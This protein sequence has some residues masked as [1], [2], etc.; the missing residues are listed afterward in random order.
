MPVMDGYESTRLIR[1]FE[2]EKALEPSF[3][4]AVSGNFISKSNSESDELKVS[5]VTLNSDHDSNSLMRVSGTNAYIS[6]PFNENDIRKGLDIFFETEIEKSE[7]TRTPKSIIK[8]EILMENSQEKT[9]D[10]EKKKK[11]EILFD[12]FRKYLHSILFLLVFFGYIKY[13]NR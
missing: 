3:I 12:F 11:Q 8:E 7:Q 10:K 6:K 5:N 1:K 4:M 13:R 9:I 2:N